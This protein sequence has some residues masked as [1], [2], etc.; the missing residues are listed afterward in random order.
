MT[1]RTFLCAY[2]DILMFSYVECLFNRVLCQNLYYIVCLLIADF[3]CQLHIPST[4]YYQ[5]NVAVLFFQSLPWLF[6]FSV[7]SSKKKSICYFEV[8]SIKVSSLI[9]YTCVPCRNSVSVAKWFSYV[10]YLKFNV[11]WRHPC[12]FW[13]LQKKHS[14]FNIEYNEI[15]YKYLW[16]GWGFSF[17][18]CLMKYLF[19]NKS[20]ILYFSSF[21]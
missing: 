18:F 21:E 15:F 16:S 2:L 11:V 19:M 7:T 8:Q 10:F 1:S 20:W 12:I 9:F 13:I 3:K 5:N 14:V 4:I 6:I 17:F